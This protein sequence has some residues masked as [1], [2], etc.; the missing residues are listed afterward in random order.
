MKSILSYLN[1]TADRL[2]DKLAFSDGEKGL[3]FRQLRQAAAGIGACLKNGG[4]RREPV[5]VL[6]E[7]GAEEVAAFLGVME[8]G[9]F[10]VPL[11]EQMPRERLE[12]IVRTLNPRFILADKQNLTAAEGLCPA[13]E[14]LLYGGA[15]SFPA[16]DRLREE[17]EGEDLAYVVFTS[18]ST[19]EPKGVSIRNSS[20]LDYAQTLPKALGFDESLVFGIQ[21]PLYFD[22]WLK[23]LLGVIVAGGTAYLLPREL[24]VNPMALIQYINDRGINALCWVSSAFSL[25]SRLRTFRAIRPQG[26]KLLCFGSEVLP[27]K[28]LT[29]WQQACPEARIFQLYGAT[30]CTGMSCFHPILGPQDPDK[31]VPVGKPFPGTEVIL[32]NDE[33]RP[34]TEGEIV[35]GGPCVMAGYYHDPVRTAEVFLPDPRG[36]GATFYR[37]G[38]RGRWD[39]NGDLVFLG[40]RDRQVKHMGHRVE[41]GEVEAAALSLKGV[42]EAACLYVADR[43]RIDLFY[44]GPA[45]PWDVVIGLKQKLPG[46]MTPSRT[47]Q[48]PELPHLPNGKLDRRTIEQKEYGK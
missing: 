9:C 8:A 1:G 15:A 10:Y 13:A 43:Q 5:G 2:P 11:D 19:G 35:I 28:Q 26:M 7:R 34:D 44:S 6:M 31:P 17:A 40:R 12:R 22:A 32:L 24:F 45:Q 46:Y 41:L 47:E 38:D 48:R 21:S 23:E 29:D 16:P 18:G 30:E 4:A 37:T 39:E 36:S 42:H 20:L 14:H 3:T 27:V 33:G 25:V